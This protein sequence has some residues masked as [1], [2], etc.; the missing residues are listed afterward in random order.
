MYNLVFGAICRGVLL[1]LVIP[2]SSSF[3]LPRAKEEEKNRLATVK[4]EGG[5]SQ[6]KMAAIVNLQKQVLCE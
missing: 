1:R 5:K 6:E 4:R 3:S 2:P